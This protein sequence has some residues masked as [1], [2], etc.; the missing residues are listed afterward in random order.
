MAGAGERSNAELDREISLADRLAGAQERCRS[1]DDRDTALADRG[2]GATERTE[3]EFDRERASADRGAGAHERV[4]AEHDR[5]S[6][7]ADR[8]ASAHEREDA[9]IDSLT[10]VS[11]RG[12]GLSWLDREMARARRT[13]ETLIL[14]F[15]DVDHL[16]EVNDAHGHA[17]GDQLLVDVARALRSKLRSYDVIFRYGGDEFVCAFSA[18]DVADAA[19]RLALVNT[20]LAQGAL[21]GSVTAGLAELRPGDSTE[22]LVARAD[23]ALYRQ[24]QTR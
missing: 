19:N 17:A 5:T 13:F 9:S 7:H 18:V 24:R 3:A 22:D 10:G 20:A 12:A 21:P 11:I 4:E 23:A 6:A 14:A 16:K 1:D 8:G 2:A 15:V